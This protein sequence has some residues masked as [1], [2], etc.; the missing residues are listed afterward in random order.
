MEK[1]SKSGMSFQNERRF[2]MTESSLLLTF[3]QV[4]FEIPKCSH[5][6]DLKMVFSFGIIGSIAATLLKYINNPR[7]QD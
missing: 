1:S 3:F 2:L 5:I 6:F 4:S 7:A